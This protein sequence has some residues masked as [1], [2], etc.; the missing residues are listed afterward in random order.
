[1]IRMATQR[2]HR[3]I[4]LIMLLQ[5]GR[6]QTPDDLVAELQVSRRTIFRDLA[7]LKDAGIP[8]YH[9]PDAG[10][11]IADSHYLPSINLTTLETLGLLL[12]GKSAAANRR[13]PLMSQALSAINKL[14]TTVPEP[15]RDACV[16]MLVNVSVA[17]APHSPDDGEARHYLDLQRCIDE[18]RVCAMRYQPAGAGATPATFT[19]RPLALHFAVR[20][21]YVM[22][23]LDG[24][25]EVRVFKLC[26]ILELSPLPRR[27][28][29]ERKFRVEDK[30]GR[31]WQL[32]PEGREYNVELLFT[33]KVGRNVS[34]VR[35]HPTQQHTIGPDGRCRMRFVVDGLGEIAWWICGYADQ[36][37]VVKP[38]ALR[39]KVRAMHRA[40]VQD[41][42]PQGQVHGNGLR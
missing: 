5:S 15:I 41:N 7:L 29:R 21:W 27:F 25:E 6:A 22:G 33:A 4:R 24:E 23:E 18:K 36:V 17:E 13:K 34:E 16:D 3:L 37:E 26:R 31:A 20:S 39:E 19:I 30:L 2:I 14:A 8:C 9:D 38:K 12:L 11:R 32:I 40:A 35:W 28:G 42:E 1:M 10:Y